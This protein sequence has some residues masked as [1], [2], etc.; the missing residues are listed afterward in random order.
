MEFFFLFERVLV[1]Y[2]YI[3]IMIDYHV[4]LYRCIRVVIEAIPKIGVI[5]VKDVISHISPVTIKTY[6]TTNLTLESI[7]EFWSKRF[8]TRSLRRLNKFGLLQLLIPH[9]PL[10][11]LHYLKGQKELV[12]LF[13]N[14]F[15]ITAETVL[16]SPMSK[17]MKQAKPIRMN[18]LY[19]YQWLNVIQLLQKQ[20]NHLCMCVS[21]S[22]IDKISNGWIRDLGFNPYLYQ[23]SI[24][25]L[26]WW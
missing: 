24:G 11:K 5:P 26:V 7:F 6:P 3:D 16:K 8:I 2:Y 14:F 19:L 4:F 1:T 10:L 15:I 17:H 13:H 22:L 9:L 20:L 23:K 25:V 18:F 21:I 12:K